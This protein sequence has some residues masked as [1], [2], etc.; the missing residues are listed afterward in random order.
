MYQKVIPLNF[1]K[2]STWVVRPPSILS[3]RQWLS[4]TPSSPTGCGSED[5]VHFRVELGHHPKSGGGSISCFAPNCL[6]MPVIQQMQHSKHKMKSN[7]CLLFAVM[8]FHWGIPQSTMKTWLHRCAKLV[9]C[10]AMRLLWVNLFNS[11]E[12]WYGRIW[13]DKHGI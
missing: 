5:N 10:K 7:L 11:L 8:R 4:W 1:A 3:S 6:K 9:T 2:P 13:H 12:A